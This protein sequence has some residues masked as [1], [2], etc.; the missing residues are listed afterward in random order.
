MW[1]PDWFYRILPFMYSVTGLL[2]FYY[3]EHWLGF[4]SG[5]LLI[6]AGIIVWKLRKEFKDV[7][8]ET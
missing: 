6:T 8:I 2:C 1:L 3:S 4:V 7:Q 5:S